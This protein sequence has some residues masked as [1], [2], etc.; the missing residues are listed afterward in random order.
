MTFRIRGTTPAAGD[1]TG[2]LFAR[3]PSSVLKDIE[4][5][6][7]ARCFFGLIALAMIEDRSSVCRRPMHILAQTAGICTRQARRLVAELEARGHVERDRDRTQAGAPSIIRTLARTRAPHASTRTNPSDCNRTNESEHTDKPVRPIGPNNPS[8][9]TKRT[10]SLIEKGEKEMSEEVAGRIG[11]GP[12]A[13][14]PSGSEPT[15]TE[16]ER[17][18]AFEEF[19]RRIGYDPVKAA[20]RAAQDEA[21]LKDRLRG[22]LG[23]QKGPEGP[24]AKTTPRGMSSAS[25]TDAKDCTTQTTQESRPENQSEHNFDS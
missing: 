21:K 5:S 17:A 20:N 14:D 24:S 15:E 6:M 18:R 23:A 19:K 3:V 10:G 9:R 13:A 2:E 8:N 25:S 4:L 12:Q 1:G 11:S 16:E 7:D 22:T